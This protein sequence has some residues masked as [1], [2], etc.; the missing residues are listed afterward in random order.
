MQK[1]YRLLVKIH[2]ECCLIITEIEA[3][4]QLSCEIDEINYEVLFFFHFMNFRKF[5][6]I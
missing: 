5:L 1:A 6:E 2:E 4:G 3:S